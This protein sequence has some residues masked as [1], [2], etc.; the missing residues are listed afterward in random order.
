MRLD[1]SHHREEKNPMACKYPNEATTPR[2]WR[3][4]KSGRQL[5][6]DVNGWYVEAQTGE[7]I[8][9]APVIELLGRMINPEIG[10]GPMVENGLPNDNSA[11]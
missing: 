3:A 8:G 7:L 9:P 4:L 10:T 5:R 1:L 11:R 6:L 2:V